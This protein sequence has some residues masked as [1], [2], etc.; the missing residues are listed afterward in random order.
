MSECFQSQGEDMALRL[1]TNENI[2]SSLIQKL[3][4]EGHDVVSIKDFSPGSTDE[5]VYAKAQLEDRI[6]LT[7]DKDFGAL[8]FLRD[9]PT[10]PGVILLRFTS[11]SPDKFSLTA[12]KMIGSREDW[13]GHFSVITVDRIR[14]RSLDLS[15]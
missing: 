7:Q 15:E 5:D 8:F 4:S 6:I 14:M 9:L 2:P 10:P 1:L 3:R 13:Y 11:P 12:T